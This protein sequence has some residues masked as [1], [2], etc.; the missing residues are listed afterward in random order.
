MKLKIENL[1]K[2]YGGKV[3]LDNINFEADSL[4]SLAII[5]PSG[6]GKSTLLRIIA[7]LERPNTGSIWINGT[8]L[9]YKERVIREYRKSIGMVFQSYNLFPHL[10]AIENITLPMKVV[11][12]KNQ[13]I[14]ENDAIGLLKKF[15]LFEHKD[16][17]PHQ[18]SGG[19]KQRIALAR[20]LALNSQFLLLDEPTSALDPELTNEVLDMMKELKSE[21]KQDL[22]LVTHE[23]GFAKR[24]CDETL[25]IVDGKIAE[26][27]KSEDLF[28][29]PKSDS[30]KR[31]LEKTFEWQ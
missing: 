31:F 8:K 20:A 7:G 27:G 4:K 19:Q 23:M 6:G 16:K 22:I 30:L 14:A 25:F 24:A 13:D 5:G 2:C 3:I 12:N 26:Y 21:E 29:R 18:L 17:K 15:Q 11:H 10:T 9:E 1:T 28:K